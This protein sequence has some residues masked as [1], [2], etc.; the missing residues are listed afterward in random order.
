MQALADEQEDEKST[1]SS[2][3]SDSDSESSSFA[4][5][6]CQGKQSGKR[7]KGK[8]KANAKKKAKSDTSSAALKNERSKQKE[9]DK[10]VCRITSVI[11]TQEKVLNLSTELNPS[12]V[13]KSSIRT[14]ELERRLSKATV[15]I[16]ELQSVQGNP[17]VS[18]D[19]AGKLSSVLE[20]LTN[21]SKV[22]G[23][24]KALCL[25]IRQAD[26]ETLSKDVLEDGQ[27][28]NHVSRCSEVLLG[29]T[30][31]FGDMVHQICKKLCE[32][33]VP[34]FGNQFSKSFFYDSMI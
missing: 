13:W 23:S 17:H 31:T 6:E 4:K 26:P 15:A 18:E 32:V 1:S 3:S 30:T 29:D 16:D 12:A 2:S 9:S 7:P 5:Q 34:A 11:S 14:V 20:Q 8:A 27:I 28:P 21:L 33:T 10:E 19:V 24:L 25:L 22:Y